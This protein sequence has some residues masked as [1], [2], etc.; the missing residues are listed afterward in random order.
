MEIDASAFIHIHVYIWEDMHICI[1]HIY[2]Y[3]FTFLDMLLPQACPRSRSPRTTAHA[4]ARRSCDGWKP[5]AWISS[6]WCCDGMGL[7]PQPR[8]ATPK[9][10]ALLPEFPTPCQSC[11]QRATCTSIHMYDTHSQQSTH[12]QSPLRPRYITRAYLDSLT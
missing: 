9:L 2:I 12:V 4:A 3:I 5:A 7:C 10:R 6:A 1:I 11:L 8:A